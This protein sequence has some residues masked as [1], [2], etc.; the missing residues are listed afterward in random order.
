VAKE[1][2]R[3]IVHGTLHLAGLDHHR[4]AERRHMR[5]RERAAMRAAAGEIA[6]ME[7]LLRD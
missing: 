7:R 1:L 2:A 3:L 5:S 4:E 6:A